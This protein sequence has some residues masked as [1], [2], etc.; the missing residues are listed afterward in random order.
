MSGP[1]RESSTLLAGLE[2]LDVEQLLEGALNDRYD[3]SHLYLCGPKPFMDTVRLVAA[4]CGWP[5]ENVHIEYFA[6]AEPTV[7]GPQT[8]FDVKLARSGKTVSI[9]ETKTIVDV[10]RE[11]GIDIET[12]CEQGVCGTCVARVLDGIPEHHDC[13]LTSQEQARGEC[14]AVCVSRSKS[15]LLVLDL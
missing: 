4:R 13:F 12:S 7:E 14:M 6:A 9:P 1:L 3:G 15:K 11:E 10:L 5:D 8:A 2:R